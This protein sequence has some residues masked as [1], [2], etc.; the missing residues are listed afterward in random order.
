MKIVDVCPE[1]GA[2]VERGLFSRYGFCKNEK[3][4][5]VLSI[6]PLYEE[7]SIGFLYSGAGD[8][9]VMHKMTREHFMHI[10]SKAVFERFVAIRDGYL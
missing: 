7:K 2:L 4:I 9:L 10:N 8:P 6:P 1:C 3:C 5:M